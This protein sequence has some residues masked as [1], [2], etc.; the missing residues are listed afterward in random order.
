MLALSL[1]LPLLP[2]GQNVE[3]N[4]FELRHCILCMHKAELLALPLQ[5]LP[6]PRVHSV[7]HSCI[8]AAIKKLVVTKAIQA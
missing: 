7:Q 6:R 2:L 3:S 8:E 5:D 1:F 4:M